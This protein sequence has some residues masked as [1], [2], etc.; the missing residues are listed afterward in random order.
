MSYEQHAAEVLNG[1]KS[2]EAEKK[3]NVSKEANAKLGQSNPNY[4]TWVV[5]PTCVFRIGFNIDL[6]S[7]GRAP[8]WYVSY[9][10]QYMQADV[11]VKQNYLT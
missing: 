7:F 11:L 10:V 9:G 6:V 8:Y 4:L 3:A 5:R 2:N 1:N